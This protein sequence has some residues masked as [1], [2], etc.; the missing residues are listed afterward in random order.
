MT[1]PPRVAALD[2]MTAEQACAVLHGICT[3]TAWVAGVLA[4]RPF[5]D[6]QALL[7]AAEEV[8]AGLDEAAVDEAL[9]GHPRIGDRAAAAHSAASAREQSGV[10][11]ADA[12]VLDGLAA[13]NA[14]YEARFGHVYLV[15]ASGRGAAE[16]LEVLRTR[17]GNDPVTERAVL[18][19]E[20]AAI[21]R[22]RIGRWVSGEAS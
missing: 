18:R 8:L 3:S 20:L 21:N 17:L 5:G 1:P 7:A 16:L 19:R 12:A 2:A 15:C 4:H 14:A 9:A 10:S 22:I 11:G 6:E 13:G